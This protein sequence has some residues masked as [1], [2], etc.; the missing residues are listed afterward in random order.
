MKY[1]VAIAKI[2]CSIEAAVPM[3]TDCF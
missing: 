2:M 1:F 3:K